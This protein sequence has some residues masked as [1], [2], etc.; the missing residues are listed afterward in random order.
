[1]KN[2]SLKLFLNEVEGL[3]D[4]KEEIRAQEM[5]KLIS[6]WKKLIENSR[7]AN[8]SQ[9][10]EYREWYYLK[11]SVEWVK[12]ILVI[13]KKP[14]PDLIVFLNHLIQHI[15]VEINC[16]KFRNDGKINPDNL[17]L[18][19]YKDTP[20]CWT[21]SKR[22]LLELIYALYLTMSINHGKISLKELVGFFSHTFHIPLPGYHTAIKKMTDRTPQKIHLLSRSFFL[23]EVVIKFNSKFELLDEN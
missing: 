8:K 4:Q 20:L 21:A 13:K 6:K 9:V 22:A 15:E 17:N 1:M 3:V 14:V 18:N 12:D 7:Q 23:N 16:T 2:R 10:E 11:L 19:V 5:E